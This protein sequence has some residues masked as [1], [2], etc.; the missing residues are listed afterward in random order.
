[1]K[2]T[3]IHAWMHHA[4]MT[5][6][7]A[8]CCIHPCMYLP[9]IG[10]GWKK[11]RGLYAVGTTMHACIPLRTLPW[12]GWGGGPCMHS[13]CVIDRLM[14]VCMQG[15]TYSMTSLCCNAMQCNAMHACRRRDRARAWASSSCQLYLPTNAARGTYYVCSMRT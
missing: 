12:V 9:L 3:K 13:T 2:K 10:F 5:C 15:E 7:C 14:H 4:W 1:M 11:V 8:S 6:I